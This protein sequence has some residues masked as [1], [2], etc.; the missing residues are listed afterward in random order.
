MSSQIPPNP[1]FSGINFNPTFFN[2]SPYLTEAIANSKY[3]KLISGSGSYTLN[4]TTPTPTQ[5]TIFQTKF[6]TFNQGDL[7]L[8]PNGGYVGIGTNATTA[9][10]LFVNGISKFSGGTIFDGTFTL[11]YTAGTDAN[12]Q[13]GQQNGYN[14]AKQRTTNQYSTSANINDIVLRSEARILFQAGGGVSAMCIN[15]NNYIQLGNAT[16]V[17]NFPITINS[18]A[19]VGETISTYAIASTASYLG[20][21]TTTITPNFILGVIGTAG[22]SSTLYIYSDK[23]IKKDIKKIEN[24]LDLIEKINPISYKYIDFVK[25]GTIN[26]Y[27]VIAQE[28]ENIIPDIINKTTDYIPNIY[29]NVDKYDNELLSLYISGEEISIGDKLKIFDINNKEH[30]KKVIDK[31]DDYITIDEPIKDYEEGSKIFIYGKEIN[32]LKN[33]NYEALFSINLKATQELYN[34]IKEQDKRIKILEKLL[35]HLLIE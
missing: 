10:K 21:Q 30:L 22:F 23:R 6:S 18:S 8:Q 7:L 33:V 13:I 12:I 4:I 1:F 35:S 26:N 24:S 2:S 9:Y 14:L 20:G 15:N 17:A 29:K 16:S 3:L 19:S 25:N 32:D 28:I 27:G 31:N 5:S 34:L 11:G